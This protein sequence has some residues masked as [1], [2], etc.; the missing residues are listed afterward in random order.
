[1]SFTAGAILS[2]YA[3]GGVGG[4]IGK[5][6]TAL[7][8]NSTIFTGAESIGALRTAVKMDKIFGGIS[9]RC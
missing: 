7:K 3:M 6:A 8:I 9:K 2:A 1:M 4:L 5:A